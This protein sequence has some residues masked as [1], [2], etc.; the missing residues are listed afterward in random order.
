MILLTPGPTPTPEY[1]RRAMAK[2]S[3]HHRTKEFEDIFA[4]TRFFLQKIFRMKENLVLS[5]SGT[6]AMEASVINFCKKKALVVNAGKFGERFVKICKSFG[7]DVVEL[8]YEWNTPASV[9]DVLKA[10]E[11]NSDIDALFIQVVE[12][13]GGLRHP[14]KEIAKAVKEINKDI[15]VVADGITAVMVEPIDTTNIDVLIAGSQKAFML[16]PGLA[17]MGLSAKAEEH[18]NSTGGV[19]YYFNLKAELDKQ[20]KNTTAYTANTTLIIGLNALLKYTFKKYGIFATY[21]DSFQRSVATREA[22]KAIGLEIYPKSPA[23]SMTTIYCEHSNEVR[24]I[25]KDKY[26]VNIAGGQDHLKGKIFRINHMGHIPLNEASW[27]V[28]AIE[29]ALAELKIREF[30]GTANRVF[31]KDY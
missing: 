13:A 3:I 4:D 9:E 5:S 30:D 18:L 1:V 23:I 25:L 27:V 7:K 24:K 8:K 28:N 31:L 14:V 26:G 19:G 20:K 12:S 6:G 21:L 11:Q 22:L 2:E 29:L 16:P 10:L 17:M 15:I